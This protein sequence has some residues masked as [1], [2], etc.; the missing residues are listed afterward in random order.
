MQSIDDIPSHLELALPDVRWEAPDFKLATECGE[1]PSWRLWQ[2]LEIGDLGGSANRLAM[3]NVLCGAG[4]ADCCFVYLLAGRPEG[5]SL[6]LGVASN[7]ANADLPEAGR[8]LRAVFEGNFLGAKLC[9]VNEGDRAITQLLDG[10]RHLGILAGVPGFNE[11]NAHDGAEDVQ[12]VERLVNVMAGETWQ[13]V[14][15]AQAGSQG[16]RDAT[17]QSI[18]ELCTLLSTRPRY[19]IQQSQQEEQERGNTTHN[20]TSN[21][22]TDS[23][24]DVNQTSKSGEKANRSGDQTKSETKSE[25]NSASN[26]KTEFDEHS[27]GI[28][29]DEVEGKNRAYRATSGKLRELRDAH[30]E[31]LESHARDTLLERFL[32]GNGK[33]MFKTTVF[34]GATTRAAYERLANSTL[35]IFQGVERNLTPLRVH[36]LPAP[37]RSLDELLTPRLLTSDAVAIENTLVHSVPFSRSSRRAAASSWLNVRELAL[38]AGLPNVELPGL[39]LRPSVD[40]GL[41]TMPTPAG[42]TELRLGLTVQNGRVLEQ[43]PLGIPVRELNKHVF[44]TGVTGAGKTTTCMKLLEESG[45]PFLVIEPAKTEYRALHPIASARP[46]HYYILGREDLTPFRLNPFE[47]VESK[48]INL[49]GHVAQL[50][51][52]LAAVFPM[53][54]AMPYLV[55]EAIV[56][57]YKARGWD[58]HAGENVFNPSPWAE[59]STAW[60]TFSDLV[61]ELKSVVVSK[62]MGEDFSAKYLGSLVAQ[63]SNLT[64]G[65]KGRMLNTP[66]SMDFNKLLDDR[67]VIELEEMKNEQDK[68]LL[69][70][71][72]IGRVADCMKQRYLRRL[73][74]EPEFRHLT[75]VEEAHRLLSRPEP[76]DG[77]ARKAGVEMFANLLSEVRKYGEGLIIADQIPNKL[78][79]DVI[80][81][82][83]IKIVHRLFAA[84]DR[85]A[86]GDTMGLSERQKDFLPLLQQGQAVVYCGGWHAPVLTQVIQSV[87]TSDPGIPEA[88][89]RAIGA[90]QAARQKSRL[91]PHLARRPELGDP[92]RFAKFLLDGTLLLNLLLRLNH[93]GVEGSMA[94]RLRD[95]FLERHE[96]ASDTY[97]V[98]LDANLAYLLLDASQANFSAHTPDQCVEY[99]TQGIEALRVSTERFGYVVSSQ[100]PRHLFVPLAAIDSI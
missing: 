76:G 91:W 27:R 14:L 6:Y 22:R 64:L 97:G 56:N 18:L 20:S 26:T 7:N 31:M 80:K 68:A 45:L 46:I 86:V 12:G 83:N 40:F 39:K 32:Q 95:A 44:I 70:G 35:A 77:G 48:A 1:R 10:N 88:T 63:L 54:A 3:T 84:D 49:A 66:R 89:F 75:L 36:K 96:R 85:H 5:I 29:T 65:V 47:L 69:M 87:D 90:V 30:G 93:D 73:P 53:E 4:G 21:A 62:E 57:A 34:L 79:P 92:A 28:T 8:S 78:I 100:G 17:V 71:L 52:T 13:F 43:R 23:T 11:T 2:V 59:G 74:S 9:Q 33:G 67:V 60:P 94:G 81:N 50:T 98:M 16:E 42:E 41:N 19:S 82:T 37:A 38:F 24:S 55:E 25:A 99:L 61:R 15:T 51:A 72:I 58:V